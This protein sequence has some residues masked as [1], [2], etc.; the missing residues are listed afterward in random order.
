MKLE[1]FVLV[2][3]FKIN[4]DVLTFQPKRINCGIGVTD[5]LV[6]ETL[7]IIFTLKSNSIIFFI[8]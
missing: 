1:G 5:H 3:I 7:C 2:T 4:C 6:Y 8:N